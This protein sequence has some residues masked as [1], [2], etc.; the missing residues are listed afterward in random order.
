MNRPRVPDS[1]IGGLA[2]LPELFHA[3]AQLRGL[4]LT[5][6]EVKSVIALVPEPIRELTCFLDKL[7]SLWRYD[8]GEPFEMSDDKVLIGCNVFNEVDR[9]FD[10]LKCARQRL[11]PE[12]LGSYLKRLADP[13]KH[14]EMLAEFVPILRLSPA[15][16]VEYEVSGY[17]EGNKTVDWLIRS[18]GTSILIE[19]KRRAT[20]LIQSLDR[21]YKGETDPEGTAPAPTH[22]VS[23]L[24]RSVEAK[25]SNRSPDQ[26]IQAA[27]IFTFV[28]QEETE[29]QSAFAALDP[30]RVH[31][32]IIGDW[33]DE[34][35]VLAHDTSVKE[36]TLKLLG[37]RESRR[38]VF[39][40]GES[41]KPGS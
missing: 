8:Y 24:F 10:V 21:L 35:F 26:M 5:R 7:T 31:L 27:W 1:I 6:D 3:A 41:P 11:K 4:A 36:R 29:L 22:D 2:A 33:E 19:V 12:Q 38:A 25:L 37:L 28:R 40:R 15:I 17:G 32:A 30:T 34:V 39:R 20:D 9:L 16:E 14:Q 18:G 23:L 13:V